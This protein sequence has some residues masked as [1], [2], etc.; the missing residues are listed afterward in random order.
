[1]PTRPPVGYPVLA[2][3]R[4]MLAQPAGN[5]ALNLRLQELTAV[6]CGFS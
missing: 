5:G 6:Q 2:P 3:K 4:A 1:M